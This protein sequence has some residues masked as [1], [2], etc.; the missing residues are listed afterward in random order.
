MIV[1]DPRNYRTSQTGANGACV[2]DTVRRIVF[3]GVAWRKNVAPQ[4]LEWA[5]KLYSVLQLVFFSWS[6]A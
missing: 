3:E 6:Q 5:F 2:I 1:Q 4:Y